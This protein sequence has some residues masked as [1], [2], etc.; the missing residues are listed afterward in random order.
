VT[1][2]VLHGLDS[3][4]SIPGRVKRLFFSTPHRSDRLWGPPSLLF[5]GYRGSFPW[6]KRPVHE[7]DHPPVVSNVEI[8]NGGAVPPLSVRLHGL[9]LKN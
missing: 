1:D 3:L 2:L 7:A 4:S 9:V 8:K 6:V 5:S